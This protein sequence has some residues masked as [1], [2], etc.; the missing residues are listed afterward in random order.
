MEQ[1]LGIMFNRKEYENIENSPNESHSKEKVDSNSC[2][3]ANSDA[4]SNSTVLIPEKQKSPKKKKTKNEK[5]PK[6]IKQS[7]RSKK[8]KRSEEDSDF[9]DF[10]ES[11]YF[12]DNRIS[13]NS[14]RYNKNLTLEESVKECVDFLVNQVVANLEGVPCILI[15]FYKF[16]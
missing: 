10:D 9:D 7:K 2:L 1:S 15:S 8:A 14:N 11:N 12:S 3:E 4:N 6:T 5:R 16:Y 13:L